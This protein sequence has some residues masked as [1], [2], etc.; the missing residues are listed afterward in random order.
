MLRK[1]VHQLASAGPVY[2]L[3]QT[4]LGIKFLYSRI[5]RVL[6]ANTG[7]RDV[8]DLGGG[9]GRIHAL[10]DPGSKYYCLDNEAPKLLQFRKHTPNGM[11]ILGDAARAPVASGS[12]DLVICV[13]VSHHLNDSE[14]QRMLKETT[15]VLRPDGRLIFYDALWQPKWIPG[16]LLWS[17]DRGSYPRSKATLLNALAGHLRIFHQE[18]V[19]LAHQYVLLVASK[20]GHLP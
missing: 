15:R 5:Q 13:A 4:A 12:M 7:Y 19:R 20:T 3:I 17:L 8:L 9:T 6:D 14:L 2:D 11:A 16:R 1:A 18:E 10:L